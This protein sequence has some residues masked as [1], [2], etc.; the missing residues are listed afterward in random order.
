MDD[1]VFQLTLYRD[2]TVRY[3]GKRTEKLGEVLRI[4]AEAADEGKIHWGD[5]LV[6]GE[7]D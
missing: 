5:G 1:F 4:L 3:H 6:W 7:P 2:G